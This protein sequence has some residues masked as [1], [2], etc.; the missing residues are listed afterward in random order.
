MPHERKIGQSLA[1]HENVQK[2]GLIENAVIV[3]QGFVRFAGALEVNGNN[4]VVL[5]Q[6]GNKVPPGVSRRAEAMDQ[7]PIVTLSCFFHPYS[8]RALRSADVDVVARGLGFLSKHVQAVPMHE[9]AGTEQRQR[10]PA[11]HA[12]MSQNGADECPLK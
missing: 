12:F 2:C 10:E 6:I 4:T 3:V 1:L 9:R 11:D 5:R 7:K 8:Q